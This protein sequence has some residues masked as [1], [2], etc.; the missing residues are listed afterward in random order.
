MLPQFISVQIQLKSTAMEPLKVGVFPEAP[1]IKPCV[2]NLSQLTTTRS[3]QSLGIGAEILGTALAIA[4][5]SY[6]LVPL[7]N[8]S[9]S[10]IGAYDEGMG[11]WSGT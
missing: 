3:C 1:Y 9:N 7:Q 8:Y 11:R 5:L 4:Q 2:L 6:V 10:D